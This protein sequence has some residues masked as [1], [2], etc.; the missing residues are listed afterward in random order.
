MAF[1]PLRSKALHHGRSLS[2][3]SKLN[4][5][6]SQ[7]EE[8]LSALKGSEACCSSLSS[9]NNRIN[10]LKNLYKTIDDLLLL[11]HIQ[12]IISLE[13]QEKWVDQVLDGYIT[14]LDACTTAKDLFSHTK[15]GVQELL[16]ALR[17]KDVHGIHWYLNSRRKWKKIIQKSLKDLRSF[18][19][20]NNVASL[21]ND[22]EAMVLVYMLKETE[23]VTIT[24]LE[25]LLS[26]L[27]GTKDQAR[28]SGWSL[29]SKLIHSKK[30]S[31]QGEGMDV[32][33]FQKMDALL[34]VSLEDIHVEEVMAR[35]KEM[36]SSIQN[37]EED[38][39]CLFR[40]LIKTR[41]FL[42]NILNH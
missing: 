22:D 33:E 15:H 37:L 6:T 12:Q 38:L 17:R 35:S 7:F 29:V 3:P 42:L 34:Q 36:E 11:P 28:Q 19:S 26:Y 2:F 32:N 24:M 13:S 10:G 39:E 8:N 1:S 25:S 41:V 9:M 20:K 30:A 31:F 21:E 40:Q 14:L 16:S 18:K 23:S 5:A 27:S 4:P